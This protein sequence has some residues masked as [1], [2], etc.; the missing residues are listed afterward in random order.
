[1]ER[2][3]RTIVFLGISLLATAM[4]VVSLISCISSDSAG[5]T[6]LAWGAPFIKS[7]VPYSRWIDLRETYS[8]EFTWI[9]GLVT[10]LALIALV[11]RRYSLSIFWVIAPIAFAAEWAALM[12]KEGLALVLHGVA[13][14][15]IT[16]FWILA[17]RLREDV[18]EDNKPVA[19]WETLAF[20]AL[21]VPFM[22]MR[23]YALN[24]IPSGWDTETCF[25]RFMTE[26]WDGVWRHE[27]GLFPSTTYGTIWL[28]LNH[29]LGNF[30]EP[31]TYYVQQRYLGVAISVVK[32]VVFFFFVRG[33]F[34]RFAAYF[35]SALLAFG[36]PEDWWARQIGYHHLPGLVV[37]AVMWATISALRNPSWINFL[38]ISLFTACCRFIYPSG[39]FMAFAPLSFFLVLMVFQWPQWRAHTWKIASLAIGVLFWFGWTSLING[40]FLGEWVLKPAFN[41]PSNYVLP[42]T[43]WEKIYR[44]LVENGSEFI[45]GVLLHQVHAAHWT[46]ALT[47]IP[48][49]SVT[50][51]AIILTIL[52][53]GRYLA[54]PRDPL[55]LFLLVSLFWSAVPS[56]ATS[57]ADRRLAATF[58]VMIIIAGREGAF[59]IGLLSRTVGRHLSAV[60]A[61]VLPVLVGGGLAWIGAVRFFTM[62]P[63]L[64]R[65]VGVGQVFRQEVKDETL[66]VDLVGQLQCDWFYSLYRDLKAQSCKTG[67]VS[68]QYQNGISVDS[69]I[70]SPRIDTLNWT[71]A[72]SE[73]ARC[74]EWPSKRWSRV[75]YVMTED[76]RID[77]WLVKLKA[78][79]PNGTTEVKVVDLLAHHTEKVTIFRA[80]NLAAAQAELPQ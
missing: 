3:R 28:A 11:R 42:T 67:F 44:I 48:G 29:L 8:Y 31:V 16:T 58:L 53:I 77:S 39:M 52:G 74:V 65:Q 61:L 72:R 25:F 34:G 35:A 54:R 55:G 12:S 66:I 1:M 5:Q 57:V 69:L 22:F 19:M 40:L 75:T 6:C 79:F 32:L 24:R 43:I 23:F 27:V 68:S 56:L 60:L 30:D 64:P 50:S 78:R 80:E 62:A 37:T 41:V 51:A 13:I 21:F 45:T 15:V 36:P 9:G 7:L 46:F 10:A 2:Q 49:R 70:Q 59:L 38:L 73:L 71:Y 33:C 76:P 47:P 14:T 20:L 26:T 63:G 4:Y 18:P 17:R